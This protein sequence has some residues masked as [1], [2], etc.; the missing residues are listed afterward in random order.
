MAREASSTRSTSTVRRGAS[1][2]SE[3]RPAAA[4][5]ARAPASAAWTAAVSGT[6]IWPATTEIRALP[7][8]ASSAWYPHP[9][10]LEANPTHSPATRQKHR[11]R[12]DL[13]L[14]FHGKQQHIHTATLVQQR[15]FQVPRT[16]DSARPFLE[17]LLR[18]V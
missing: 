17:A 14:K 3:S 16:A 5:S 8:P 6:K 13:A 4:S 15:A 10:L 12:R 2:A 9:A 11:L 1:D 7:D 18:L